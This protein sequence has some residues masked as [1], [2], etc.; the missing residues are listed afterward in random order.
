MAMLALA[1]CGVDGPPHQPGTDSGI[2]TGATLT[3]EAPGADD[4]PRVRP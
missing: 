4:P 3:I 2:T 1:A